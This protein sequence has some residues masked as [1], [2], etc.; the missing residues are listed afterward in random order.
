MALSADGRLF[1]FGRGKHGQL[2]L[3]NFHDASVP[4]PVRALQGIPIVQVRPFCFSE[5]VRAPPS[6]TH[7]AGFATLLRR[8]QH[9]SGP[10]E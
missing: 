2:G 3:G 10:A 5:R 4:Q 9:G 8:G 6:Q 1:A 7:T